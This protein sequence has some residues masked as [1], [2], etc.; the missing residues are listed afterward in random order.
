VNYFKVTN[1]KLRNI[2]TENTPIKLEGVVIQ[3]FS[4]FI[5]VLK[6]SKTQ[7]SNK[8]FIRKVRDLCIL[9]LRQSC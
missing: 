7:T 2:F 9:L 4:S 8:S 5:H 3:F 1:D 6:K